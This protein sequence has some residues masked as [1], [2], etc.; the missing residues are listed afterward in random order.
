MECRE[1]LAEEGAAFG[2]AK[3]SSKGRRAVEEGGRVVGVCGGEGDHHRLG[4]QEVA[5]GDSRIVEGGEQGAWVDGEVVKWMKNQVEDLVLEAGEME[6]EQELASITESD[7][8]MVS[9]VDKGKGVE[10]VP[11]KE[12]ED[13]KELT[14]ELSEKSNGGDDIMIK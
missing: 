2:L 12:P 1:S 9:T 13:L 11:E 14:K 5:E 8:E 4:N 10:G 6:D 3:G 7:K